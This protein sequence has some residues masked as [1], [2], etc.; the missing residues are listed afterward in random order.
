MRARH[1]VYV[2]APTP[3]ALLVLAECWAGCTFA[4]RGEAVAVAR[5][6]RRH[7]RRRSVR[8]VGLVREGARTWRVVRAVPVALA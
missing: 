6:V 2:G 7:L 1:A 3:G 8:V 4:T 5:A